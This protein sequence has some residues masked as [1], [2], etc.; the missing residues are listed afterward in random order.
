[1]PNANIPPKPP[2]NTSLIQKINIFPGYSVQMCFPKML[3]KCCCVRVCVSKL[4]VRTHFTRTYFRQPNHNQ[5]NRSEPTKTST[6]HLNISVSTLY[7]RMWTFCRQLFILNYMCTLCIR[8][9]CV[10]CLFVYAVWSITCTIV[11]LACSVVY[12]KAYMQ[13][14]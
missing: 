14:G 10:R 2:T 4:L 3:S 13:F 1:M 6:S 12:W 9:F 7:C 11:I 8:T 5:M